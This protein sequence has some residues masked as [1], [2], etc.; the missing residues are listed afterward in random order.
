MAEITMIRDRLGLGIKDG[1]R[2]VSPAEKKICER[3][4]IPTLRGILYQRDDMG[5]LMFVSNN[6]V[7]LGGSIN[8]LEKLCG[9]FA[10]YRPKSLTERYQS[11]LTIAN[12]ITS[13]GGYNAE[14]ERTNE[15]KS[16]ICLFG[17]GT[18]GCALDISQVYAPDFRQ[19]TLNTNK[20]TPEGQVG[21]W[22]PLR[23]SNTETLDTP[24]VLPGEENKSEREKYHFRLKIS[25]DSGDYYAWF[26]KNFENATLENDTAGTSIKSLWRNAPD[27]SK[28][29]TEIASDAD[30]AS[31]PDGQGIES[32]AE[33]T[34]RI[35]PDDV[36]QYFT[37]TGSIETPRFNTIGLFTGVPVKV[38]ETYTEYYNVRLF[39]VVNFPNVAKS[40]RTD[41]TYV[42]RVYSAL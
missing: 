30:L 22:I 18:G 15:G 4:H 24:G 23:V 13:G 28:D 33:F 8:A 39:S 1:I 10:T 9:T 21:N 12:T 14:W 5:N 25:A 38:D 27:L 36:R 42:Y 29:G 20:E 37:D 32:F 41:M 19:S 3:N 16:H 11:Q 35:G 17:V 6:T 26:L 7:V 34:L 2:A 40:L 31:G